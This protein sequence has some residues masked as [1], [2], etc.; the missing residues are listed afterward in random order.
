AGV[1]VAGTVGA[2]TAGTSG[3]R[4]GT[5]LADVG[6]AHALWVGTAGLSVQNIGRGEKSGTSRIAA[7]LQ[8]SLAWAAQRQAG[9]LDLGFA[10]QVTVR[11]KWVAPGAGIEVG[12]GWIE[13]LSVALR[14]GARRTET[15]AER[16]VAVGA[17]VNVDRLQLDYALQSFEGARS[18]HRLTVR[19]R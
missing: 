17:T 19:W 1:A 9:Q 8:T 15:G 14:V 5:F 6:L 12:Y 16:P 10:S 2:R 3:V 4:R 13:G 18:A 7:P 11:D